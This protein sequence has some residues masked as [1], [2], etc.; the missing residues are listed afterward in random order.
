VGH[1]QPR[2]RRDVLH[3]LARRSDQAVMMATHR[4]L[5]AP[6]RRTARRGPSPSCRGDGDRAHRAARR[7]AG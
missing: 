6:L 2:T 1:G 7:R 3:H 4:P 5:S